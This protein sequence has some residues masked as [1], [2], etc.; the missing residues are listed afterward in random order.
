MKSA[1]N[2]MFIGRRAPVEAGDVAS[3]GRDPFGR[4]VVPLRRRSAFGAPPTRRIGAVREDAHRVDRF[5]SGGSIVG[6]HAERLARD[7]IDEFGPLVGERHGAPATL[8]RAALSANSREVDVARPPRPS[9]NI[10]K[11]DASSDIRSGSCCFGRVSPVTLLTAMGTSLLV[12]RRDER[13]WH[14]RSA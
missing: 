9:S 3:A 1:E 10:T 6:F 13:A 2:T 12:T 4:H 8:H 14:R 7:P 11:P 5:I